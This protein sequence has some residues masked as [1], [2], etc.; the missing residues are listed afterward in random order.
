MVDLSAKIRNQNI[1]KMAAVRCGRQTDAMVLITLKSRIM[2]EAED[3][4]IDVTCI[5]V[6]LITDHENVSS[7]FHIIDD[8]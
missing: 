2:T 7:F 1:F 3:I 6:S 4:P 8:V 5:T